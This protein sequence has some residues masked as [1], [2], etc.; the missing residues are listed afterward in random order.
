M[1]RTSSI[2]AS[3]MGMKTR[4]HVATADRE[5]EVTL[6]NKKS[7]IRPTSVHDGAR[8]LEDV[9][10]NASKLWG[11]T[12]AV[13]TKKKKKK[14]PRPVTQWESAP[15][16]LHKHQ[17]KHQH[18]H[19]EAEHREHN[20]N[21]NGSESE[22][23]TSENET[24]ES[25][26]EQALKQAR[27]VT[28]LRWSTTVDVAIK[29]RPKR[30][31][32]IMDPVL[33]RLR[34]SYISPASI[35]DCI[36]LH[37]LFLVIAPGAKK[38]PHVIHTIGL[39]GHGIPELFMRC[40]EEMVRASAYKMNILA[41]ELIEANCI[42]PHGTKVRPAGGGAAST[43]TVGGRS[44]RKGGGAT[45]EEGD[46]DDAANDAEGNWWVRSLNDD[47]LN[48]IN[49]GLLIQAATYYDSAVAVSEMLPESGW[50]LYQAQ[51]V[52]DQK[53]AE[54]EA[55]AAAVAT[56]AVA[57]SLTSTA[58]Q[59]AITSAT[60]QSAAAASAS[61][62]A[63]DGDSAGEKD[64]NV[65]DGG[66]GGNEKGM[67]TQ[68]LETIRSDSD[69]NSNAS[70]EDDDD[71]LD[72]GDGGNVDVDNLDDGDIDV[73]LALSAASPSRSP[74]PSIKLKDSGSAPKTC[75]NCTAAC[76]TMLCSTCSRVGTRNDVY[77]GYR[78]AAHAFAHAS[79]ESARRRASMEDVFNS[80]MAHTTQMT[81]A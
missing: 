52:D 51:K 37:G 36:A 46:N 57:A 23:E 69:S 18:Q 72:C 68:P 25:E 67:P 61:A 80:S 40:P 32:H 26:S 62:T 60:M 3:V 70:S 16:D 14:K 5:P 35:Q 78:K 38:Y 45:E 56:I 34:N 19:Q 4:P 33:Q 65:D 1:V 12:E 9:L 58:V 81:S 41:R 74:P 53:C 76:N 31:A 49:N 17:H 59:S 43:R 48:D 15:T 71:N 13:G 2:L 10:Q 21:L 24:S 54:Q 50:R 27:R 79:P 11:F 8:S 63:G 64:A 73:D 39:A 28:K 47:E 42:L 20:V 75:R 29:Q 22:N 6:R 44:G 30:A 55:A 77:K 66:G 7:V